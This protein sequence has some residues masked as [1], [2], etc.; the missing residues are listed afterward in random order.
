MRLCMQRETIKSARD[1]VV[2]RFFVELSL[3]RSVNFGLAHRF[4]LAGERWMNRMEVGTGRTEAAVTRG[5]FT[6]FDVS[7]RNMTKSA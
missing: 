1:V 2:M 7:P 4:D 6:T 3:G 5:I